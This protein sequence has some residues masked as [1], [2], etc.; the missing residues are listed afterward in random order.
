MPDREPVPV[1]SYERISADTT[2]DEHGVT[3]QHKINLDTATRI[4]WAVVHR[5]ADND[6]SAAKPDVVREGFESLLR[7][8]RAGRVPDGTPVRP[9][10]ATPDATIPPAAVD[11]R[12]VLDGE[13]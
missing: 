10:G 1:V 9:E 7:A 6:R 11:A 5:F 12:E 13:T 4:G 8:L 3:H 2:R